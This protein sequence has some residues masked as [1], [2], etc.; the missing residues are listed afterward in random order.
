MTAFAQH[1]ESERRLIRDQV[2]ARRGLLPVVVEKDFWVC[3]VLDWEGCM[4]AFSEYAARLGARLHPG[5][6]DECRIRTAQLGRSRCRRCLDLLQA[7]IAR[8]RTALRRLGAC[9]AQG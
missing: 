7:R 8:R 3:W 5:R 6:W 2:A 1:P 4:Q 9:L